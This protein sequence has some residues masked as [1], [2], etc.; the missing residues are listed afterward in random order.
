MRPARTYLLAAVFALLAALRAGAPLM[1]QAQAGTIKGAVKD[2][3]GAPV[4]GATVTLRSESTSRSTSVVTQPD[5]SYIFTSLEA[6]AYAVEAAREGFQKS[7]RARV[8]LGAQAQTVDLILARRDAAPYYK[9]K[10]KP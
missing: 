7:S 4:P 3:S 2:A 8:T 6:G 9:D 1:G 5:G 10:D